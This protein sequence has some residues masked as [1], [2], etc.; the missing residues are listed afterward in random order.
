MLYERHPE[1]PY[2]FTHYIYTLSKLYPE[3]LRNFEEK[4]IEIQYLNSSEVILAYC[5]RQLRL[6]KILS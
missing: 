3:Q 1:D 6:Q 2:L 4:A 5:I